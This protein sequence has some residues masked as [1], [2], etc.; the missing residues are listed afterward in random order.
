[1][2]RKT[3]ICK[4][5]GCLMPDAA[6]N[7]VRCPACA[8]KWTMKKRSVAGLHKPKPKPA[9]KPLTIAEVSQRARAEGV[10]YGTYVLRHELVHSPRETA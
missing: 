2:V 3:R 10:S 4:D 8:R 5:C 9:Q 7:R 6:A 1:M